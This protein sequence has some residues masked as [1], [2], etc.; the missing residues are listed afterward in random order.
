LELA[1]A[2]ISGRPLALGGIAKQ[3]SFSAVLEFPN[4]LV[5]FQ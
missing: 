4:T 5:D 2:A 1:G 3:D